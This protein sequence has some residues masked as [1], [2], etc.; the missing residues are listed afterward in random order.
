MF[1]NFSFLA[2]SG[3]GE[4]GESGLRREIQN[5]SAE[6]AGMRLV[7]TIDKVTT[8]IKIRS[9]QSVPRFLTLIFSEM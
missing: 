9:I 3:K 8:S 4:R 5:S 1:V 2:K 7:T 6:E